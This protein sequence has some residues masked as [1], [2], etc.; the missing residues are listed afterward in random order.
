MRAYENDEFKIP[1]IYKKMTLKQLN[2][3]GKILEIYAIIVA[4]LSRIFKKKKKNTSKIKFY[5]D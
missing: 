2:R 5:I 3:I 1:K 4:R